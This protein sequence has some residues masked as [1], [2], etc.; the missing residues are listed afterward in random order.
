[1]LFHGWICSCIC[2]CVRALLVRRCNGKQRT[3]DL[4]PCVSS[5]RKGQ[6]EDAVMAVSRTTLTI[7]MHSSLFLSLKLYEIIVFKWATLNFIQITIHR[8]FWK[9]WSYQDVTSNLLQTGHFQLLCVCAF[10]WPAVLK[11]IPFQQLPESFV[12][13]ALSPPTCVP[14]H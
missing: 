4:W 9:K 3:E 11:P 12:K 7:S 5:F 10:P 8:L 13:C 14:L 2:A 1:M 6:L